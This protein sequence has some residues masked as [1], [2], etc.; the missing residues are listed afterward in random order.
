MKGPDDALGFG[1]RFFFTF[2]FY[3]SL[4]THL[5]SIYMWQKFSEAL[6]FLSI[7]RGRRQSLADSRALKGIESATRGSRSNSQRS[8]G[9]LY[10]P[11]A[12]HKHASDPAINLISF[13][14]NV[15]GHIA[16][17]RFYS[18]TESAEHMWFYKT[19]Q[20]PFC[21]A[22]GV[23]LMRDRLTLYIYPMW[24]TLFDLIVLYLEIKRKRNTLQ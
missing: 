7:R 10:G 6:T 2:S 17:C 16:Q 1:V 9:L 3:S 23:M 8:L 22:G 15:P 21:V 13:V 20:S 18:I 19:L 4:S 11:G 5:Q 12:A 24:T 14:E